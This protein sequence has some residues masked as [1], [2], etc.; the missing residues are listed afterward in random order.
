[1]NYHRIFAVFMRQVFL[2]CNNKVRFFSAFVWMF[3]DIILWG[4]IS[5]YLGSVGETASFATI[6]LGAIIFWGFTT[7]IIQGIMTA[8]LEDGW[9]RNYINFFASPL[10]V[11]EYLCGMVLSSTILGLIGLSIMVLIAGLGFGYN[12]FKIGIMVFPFLALL[13]IFG[14]A[15]GIFVSGVIFRFGPAAEWVAWPIPFVISIF[16]GVFYPISALPT[17]MQYIAKL[18]PASYVFENMRLI[19]SGKGFGMTSLTDMLISLGLSLAYILVNYFF[20]AHVYRH[21][22]RTGSIAN[23]NAEDF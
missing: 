4:F 9:S 20:F 8:F 13:Y 2:M 14:I 19:L 5:R 7:R 17:V 18:I 16:S 11:S 12:I 6:I 23:Y 10:K 15:L 3:F 1:M 21:N 22:L